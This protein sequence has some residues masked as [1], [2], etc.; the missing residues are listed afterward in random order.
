MN[1]RN[2]H[3]VK[4]CYS[5]SW[6]GKS[7][8]KYTYFWSLP[9]MKNV[10]S[11]C[12]WY[13]GSWQTWTE[14]TGIA[15]AVRVSGTSCVSRLSQKLSS[16]L[17]HSTRMMLLFCHFDVTMTKPPKPLDLPWEVPFS[18]DNSFNEMPIQFVPIILINTFPSILEL[19]AFVI[20]VFSQLCHLHSKS[21][22]K[23]PSTGPPPL[24]HAG[25]Y[26]LNI[27]VQFV[28]LWMLNKPHITKNF[29]HSLT[30][31]T[32]CRNSELQIFWSPR[33]PLSSDQFYTATQSPHL[34][35]KNRKIFQDRAII[36]Q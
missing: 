27:H 20:S 14:I 33:D 3:Q 31:Q 24:Y 2:T 5:C 21:L 32:S 25:H 26:H 4:K 15:A 36:L 19:F 6:N 34:V 18:Q 7:S 17:P 13:D 9:L 11:D 28:C 1:W 8:S 29:L 16:H 23:L 10:L 22:L 12:L 30:K 35:Y